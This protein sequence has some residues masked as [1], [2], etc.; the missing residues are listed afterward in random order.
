MTGKKVLYIIAVLLLTAAGAGFFLFAR[1][2]RENGQEAMKETSSASAGESSGGIVYDKKAYPPN[3]WTISME[4]AVAE[5]EASGKMILLNFTGSD[6]CVWCQKLTREV[7]SQPEFL[8]WADENLIMV[9]LDSPSSIVQ[10]D[11]VVEQNQLLQQA[12]SVQGFPSIFL[13]DSDLTPLLKTGYREGGAASYIGHLESDRLN[14]DEESAE[15][16]RAGFASLIEERLVPL[17][18]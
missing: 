15:K 13:F 12:L 2:N 1:G 3:G 16:F 6:W 18:I 11:K 14:L 5:A 17:N 8:D 4:E 7:F 10:E 9:F